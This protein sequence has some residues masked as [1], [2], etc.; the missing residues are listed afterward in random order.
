MTDDG[1]YGEKGLVTDALRKLLESG[2][3]YDEV[4]AIG[5]LVMMKFVCALTK[6]FGVKTM[7][8]MNPCLLYTSDLLVGERFVKR[9]DELIQL[10]RHFRIFADV[11]NNHIK[12][13]EHEQA[14]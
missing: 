10:I 1:S 3:K 2:E 11:V 5:P 14:A 7:I 8:S 4:I 6:E 12:R 13:T 9:D